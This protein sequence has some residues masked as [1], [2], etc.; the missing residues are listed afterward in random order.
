MKFLFVGSSPD[1]GG[2]EVHFTALAQAL[3]EQ[4]HGV[5]AMV[6]PRG[7]IAAE[8]ARANVPLHRRRFRNVIDP[9]AHARLHRAIRDF[10]PDALIGN[11]GKDYWPLVLA[12]RMAKVPVAL[13]RHSVTALNPLS[14]RWLPRLAHSYFAV[15][16]Y[17]RAVYA[18]HGMDA[19]CVQVLHNPVDVRRFQHAEQVR[20]QVLAELDIPQD[21]IVVGYCG[22]MRSKGIY[23]LLEASAL[24]MA[25][26]PRVHC[27]WVGEDGGGE[28]R[29]AAAFLP[30]ADRHR[31]TGLVDDTERYYSAFS[32]LAFPSL[33]PETFGRVS[34]EAQACGIPVLGSDIGGVPETLIPGSSGLLLPP[35]DARAWKRGILALCDP[36]ARAAMA[37][38]G[39]AFVEQRF[40]YPVIAGQLVARMQ[41]GR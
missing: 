40:S 6:D 18:D 36:A 31:F 11:F 1:H 15:S 9:C 22:R 24:A 16:H 20:A 3:Q 29:S 33:A 37:V 26:D 4:G 2:A 8:L 38:A 34:I 35:G 23:T 39:R 12:G 32:M 28:L 7:F 10:R 13:F 17:A 21:A 19:Q 14:S 41:A 30:H 5:E 25:R 27:L